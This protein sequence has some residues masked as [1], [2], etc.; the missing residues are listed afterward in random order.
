MS[1]A[2]LGWARRADPARDA[3]RP[4]LQ[5]DFGFQLTGEPLD[6]LGAEPGPRRFFHA[7]TARLAPPQLEHARAVLLDAPFDVRATAGHRQRPVLGGVRGE[8]GA[9]L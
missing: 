1:A 7:R 8:F 2:R 9:M 4:V 6:E 3:L 5:I